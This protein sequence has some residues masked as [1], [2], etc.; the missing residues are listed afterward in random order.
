VT[1]GQSFAAVALA[2]VLVPGTVWAQPAAPPQGKYQLGESL[3]VTPVVVF[4]A[5]HDTNAIRTNTGTPANEFY[6]VP[7]V[8]GWLGRGRTRLNFAT[9]VELAQQQGQQ[10]DQT[11]VRI[12]TANQYYV[13]RLDVGGQRIGIQGVAGYRDHY[14]PP[15]DFVG[16]ELGIKSRRIETELGTQVTVRPGGRV[17]L[18]GLVNL[19][20]LRYDASAIFQG[21]SLQQN[22]NR[23]IT[24]YG[25]EAQVALTPLSSVGASVNYYTDRFLY[26]P[27][28]N[29]NGTR[30]MFSAQFQPLALLAGRAEVGYLKYRALSTRAEYGGPAYNVGLSLTR[31]PVYLDISG[32]RTIEYSFDPSQGFYVSSGI[33]V[34]SGFSLGTRWEAFGR[35]SLRRLEPRGFLALQEPFRGIQLYKAG[36]VRRFGSV[37]RVGA[38]VERYITGGPGGFDGV[39]TT[40]FMIYGGSTRLQ[41][42]DRPLPGGF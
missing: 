10:G 36:L 29:G 3:S 19:A 22:L 31:A 35:G 20:R 41:R 27:L 17:S 32:R 18:L 25:G 38:D 40:V 28:R 33:D 23:D 7:Q 39:R 8:E 2:A 30:Y 13:A 6:T 9:A 24:I 42:L 11:D 15:T 5:G 1:S 16:F 21:S 12:R 37:L 4:V 26:A 34:Y 14:A